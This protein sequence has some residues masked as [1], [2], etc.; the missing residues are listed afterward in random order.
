MQLAPFGS[1]TFGT[2]ADWDPF[3]EMQRLQADMNRLF[4]GTRALAPA[5][6]YPPVNI[7]IGD[8]SVVVT[9]QMPGLSQDDIDLTVQDDTLTIRGERRVAQADDNAAWHRRERANGR[10]ARTIELPFRVDPDQVTARFNNGTLAVE[11]KRPETDK[12]R[13]IQITAT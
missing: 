9:A 4:E 3:A 8:D 6:T 2:F 1:S 13:R 11:M 7:W 10:F 12:P 5:R